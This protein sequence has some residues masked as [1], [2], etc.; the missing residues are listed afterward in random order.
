MLTFCDEDCYIKM[1][2]EFQTI[3]PIK[4]AES[5]LTNAGQNFNN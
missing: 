3:F 5:S 1:K 2:L 4:L